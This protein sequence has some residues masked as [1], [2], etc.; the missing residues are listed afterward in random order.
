MD[1]L[2]GDIAPAPSTSISSSAPHEEEEYESVLFVARESYV[3][4]L[5]ARTST[6][7]YKAAEWVGGNA[8]CCCLY[9]DTGYHQAGDAAELSLCAHLRRATWKLSSGKVCI[10]NWNDALYSDIL[11][12]ANNGES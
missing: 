11:L 1:D 4:R 7:G 10:L 8:T 2:F 3:Y 5:P 12:L 6:A 9:A